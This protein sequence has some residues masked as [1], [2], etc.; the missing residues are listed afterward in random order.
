MVT[1]Q[2]AVRTQGAVEMPEQP[3]LIPPKS[4]QSA[5]NKSPLIA[6]PDMDEVMSLVHLVNKRGAA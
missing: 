5:I 4:Y 6:L 1:A 2:G 3:G